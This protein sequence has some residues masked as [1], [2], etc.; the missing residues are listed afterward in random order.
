MIKRIGGLLS[1]LL[2]MM[3]W[4]LVGMS[5]KIPM[6]LTLVIAAMLGV[7]WCAYWAGKDYKEMVKK[8]NENSI[9]SPD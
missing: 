1:T 9:Q 7:P 8:R 6:W 2:I 5:I 3:S 4:T